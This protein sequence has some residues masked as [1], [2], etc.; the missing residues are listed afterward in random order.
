MA[1][2][3]F[4]ASLRPRRRP[5][6]GSSRTGEKCDPLTPRSRAAVAGI[7]PGLL[8]ATTDHA[9]VVIDHDGE[10]QL[11]SRAA[12]RRIALPARHRRGVDKEGEVA[13]VEVVGRRVMVSRESSLDSTPPLPWLPAHGTILDARG[14]I[15]AVV[16][17]AASGHAGGTSVIDLGDDELLVF[18]A[19]GGF[20]L[21]VRGIALEYGDLSEWHTTPTASHSRSSDA[22]TGLMVKTHE[23]RVQAFALG[24]NS[25]GET[26]NL[27]GASP[28]TYHTKQ[29]GYKWCAASEEQCH[30]G[31]IEIGF[32][33]D[34][35]GRSHWLRQLYDHVLPEC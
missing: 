27:D 18:D 7:A 20:S 19:A 15:T 2:R 34:T 22:S 17:S 4:R 25:S 10:D 31:E 33:T 5:P 23:I 32:Q 21:V 9:I 16:P 11:W 29:F 26:P 1:R 8:R 30:V 12:D 35:H 14:H 24:P 6:R 13:T 3:R 28:G